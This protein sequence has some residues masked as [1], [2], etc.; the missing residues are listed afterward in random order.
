MKALT[1]FGPGCGELSVRAVAPGA[2]LLVLPLLAACGG[3]TG[4]DGGVTA[5]EGPGES[6][7]AIASIRVSPDSAAIASLGETARFQAEARD[8]SGNAVSGVSF[9]WSSSRTGVAT[10]DP[11]GTATATGNGG[12]LIRATAAGLE[13]SAYLAVRAGELAWSRVAAGPFNSCA[14][15][16]HGTVYC[17]GSNRHGQ[18]GDDGGNRPT[19]VR[20]ESGLYF[21][22]V[23]SSGQTC[24]LTFAGAPYCWGSSAAGERGDGTMGDRSIPSRVSTSETFEQLTTGGNHTCGVTTDGV[25]HCWGLNRSGQLGDGT[26]TD[27]LEP[28]PV[29][30]S[31]VF[32]QVSAGRAPLGN[33]TCG[34]TT[35]GEAYCWGPNDDGELGDGTTTERLEPVP[36]E[37]DLSFRQV[38][39][40][41][42][43]T[44]AVT[45][46]G[47]AYCWGLN[48]SGQLGDGST[49]DRT[50]PAAV[51][52]SE[53]FE[54]ISAGDNHTCA[55][56]TDGTA[57]CWGSNG[58]GQL[59]DGGD[60]I[61]SSPVQ[62]A[63]GQTFVQLHA[64]NDHTCAV[65][66]AGAAYCWGANADGQ[67][68][69]G[70][71]TGRN[72]PVLVAAPGEGD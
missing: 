18:L 64:G 2:A 63:A 61:G 54:R 46:A 59:G 69:D 5:P 24:A 67:L 15:T 13:S 29:T 40:G 6:R 35:D 49:A 8:L 55:L 38:S 21:R 16:T 58:Q 45:T 72:E 34:V 30:G 4:G 20:T 25:A 14:A 70:T 36:V 60:G 48:R 71:F 11:A 1:Y 17:W 41:G 50:T 57:H 28:V 27:R 19:P 12:A 3:G 62:V 43:H 32:E 52:T 51:S 47:E 37:G 44:C 31:L 66:V 42:G 39:A 65:T 22:A 26:T 68:G 53:S 33:H 7:Q 23:R 56:A 10:V 9:S